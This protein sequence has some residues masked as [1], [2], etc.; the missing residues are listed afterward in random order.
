[1]KGLHV[2]KTRK[3]WGLFLALTMVFSLNLFP[4]AKVDAAG[5]K[6]VL[7]IQ[8]GMYWGGS[9][10]GEILT[11]FQTAGIITGYDVHTFTEV[12]AADFD[13]S[14][15]AL[16][17]IADAQMDISGYTETTRSKLEAYAQ[18]GGNILFGA[19]R[20][21]GQAFSALLPG[22]VSSSVILE[23]NNLIVD[24]SNPIVNGEFSDFSA[25]TDSD[26]NGNSCS[27]VSF[28]EATL[29]AG[30]NIILKAASNG[31]PTLAEF[32]LGSG[33]VIVSGLTWEF[34]YQ[35][36]STFAKKAY[37]DLI[38]SFL[39]ELQAAP[40]GLAGTATSFIGET[41]GKI[42]GTTS[43]MEYK[44]S[45]AS[46]YTPA[47]D[48]ETISLAA[49]TYDV[50]YAAKPG[51]AAS[52][53]VTV[54]VSE[55]PAR[56]YTLAVTAPA[57]SGILTT[58][59][60]PAAMPVVITSSGNSTSTITGVTVSG[61]EFV[62]AGSGNTVAAGTSINSWTVQPIAGLAAGTHTATI[63]VT[64]N[65]GAQATA[66]VTLIVATRVDAGAPVFSTNLSGTVSLAK[67]TAL[68]PLTV[69][70][71]S[72]DSG[73]VTYQWYVKNGDNGAYTAIPGATEAAYTPKTD[74]AGV[75]YY[76][77]KATNTNNSV[78]GT[79]TAQRDSE[80]FKVTVTTV[81]AKTGELNSALPAAVLI[82][83]GLAVTCAAVLVVRKR[84]LQ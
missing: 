2:M 71:D 67:G 31:Y 52:R 82:T 70:A 37:D 9:V 25:L 34:Y 35:Y 75:F 18:A 30:S 54:T 5:G 55:G 22:G 72:P 40:V 66:D 10:N 39:L 74:V 17:M 58:D 7:L 3:F 38:L 14:G 59:P 27:H 64:Y 48:T 23:A 32:P 28:D 16:V 57:F 83:A 79:K 44:L 6:Q 19:C 33:H 13:L 60:Q 42:T 78:N 68:S 81:L 36:E 73:T 12:N 47:S 51:Y 29:P 26:L 24:T 41:D 1:M 20:M 15:Y 63:T 76:L 11:G 56:T 43:A 80:V 65:D 46:T 8:S 84:K 61:S 62:I 53:P 77:A 69:K 50:R 49:G 21:S 4:A 45:S